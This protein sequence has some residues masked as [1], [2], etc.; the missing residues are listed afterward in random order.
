MSY[1]HL[2]TYERGR[3]EALHKLGYSNR[4]IASSL[5]RHRSS[6][7]REIKQNTTM[8]YQAEVAG[9]NYSNRRMYSKP[10]GKLDAGIAGIIEQK[11]RETLVAGADCKHRHLG[12]N[13]LQNHLQLA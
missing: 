13:Q 6:I 3:I 11:L 5:G 10:K 12:G 9:Q 8:A 4:Q 2:T 7:D 1:H